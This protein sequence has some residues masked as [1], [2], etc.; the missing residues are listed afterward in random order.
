MSGTVADPVAL[1]ADARARWASFEPRTLTGEDRDG[2]R[3]EIP[4]GEILAPILRRARLFGAS[5]SLCEAV[6]ARLV[7][8]GVEAVV[9][10]T[11]EDVR[12]DDALVVDGRGPVQVMALRAGERVVPVRPGAS[13]LRVWAVDGAGDPADPPVAEVVV[14]V[15]ADGWVPAGRIAEALAPHLA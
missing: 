7:A 14:D 2:R 6:V 4:P 11:R 12:E 5:T 10:R 3:L 13:L 15:D 9:D 8:A 1:E